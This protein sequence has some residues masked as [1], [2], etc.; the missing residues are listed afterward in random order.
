MAHIR[1][2]ANDEAEGLLRK[3]YDDAIKRVG[4]VFGILRVMSLNPQTLR[5]SMGLYQATMFGESP[6]SRRQREMIAT[7]VSRENECFY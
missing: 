1:Q 6:L 3:I 5:A 7:V 2:V 4:R